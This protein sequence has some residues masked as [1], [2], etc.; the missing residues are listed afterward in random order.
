[1][2]QHEDDEGNHGHNRNNQRQ[3]SNIHPLRS[4]RAL[5]TIALRQPSQVLSDPVY[6]LALLLHDTIN[7]QRENFQI[8]VE[9]SATYCERTLI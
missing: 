6:S 5:D 2:Q 8:N 7:C 4:K 1:M 3:G 9:T